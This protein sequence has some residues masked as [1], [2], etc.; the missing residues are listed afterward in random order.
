M[1]DGDTILIRNQDL[2]KVEGIYTVKSVGRNTIMHKTVVPKTSEFVCI[3]ENLTEQT[4]YRTEFSCENEF[5]SVGKKKDVQMHWDKRC[6][7]DFECPWYQSDSKYGCSNGYC[8]MPS[9]VRQVSYRYYDGIQKPN[10]VLKIPEVSNQDVDFM[11]TNITIPSNVP[12]FEYNLDEFRERIKDITI[13]KHMTNATIVKT[14]NE[15]L[16]L[17]M[18]Y[19]LIHN[20]KD[21]NI[22]SIVIH[23]RGKPYGFYIAKESSRLNIKGLVMDE[24][25]FE[26]IELNN[27]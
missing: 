16:N 22:D 18:G 27:I 2:D 15:H 11:E 17:D 25:I 14:I 21:K 26:L 5:D 7:R 12:Y 3:D 6:V 9:H 20:I 8:R 4:S 10:P 1:R 13:S 19:R 23:R 24:T